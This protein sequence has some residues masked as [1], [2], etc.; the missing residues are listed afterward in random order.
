MQSPVNVILLPVHVHV[1]TVLQSKRSKR[2]RSDD[3]SLS[4]CSVDVNTEVLC[5][6]IR[7]LWRFLIRITSLLLHCIKMLTHAHIRHLSGAEHGQVKDLHRLKK[8]FSLARL[9][10]W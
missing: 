8:L 9:P 7:M 2:V 10:S 6:V 5:A 1:F 4:L 3:D